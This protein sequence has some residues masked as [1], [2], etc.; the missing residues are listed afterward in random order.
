MIKFFK[1]SKPK[2]REFGYQPRYY[3]QEEEQRR[4]RL[5]RRGEH[6]ND[7]EITKLR[8]RDQFKDY[9]EQR[10]TPRGLWNGSTI[11]LAAIFALLILVA[12]YGLKEWLP[13]LMNYIFPNG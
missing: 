13:A 10:R 1:F 11:R 7:G 8:I 3:N 9:R 12:S 4:S 5:K 6:D 2:K